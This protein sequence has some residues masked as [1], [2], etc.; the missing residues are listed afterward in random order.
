MGRTR[1]I[2]DSEADEEEDEDEDVDSSSGES[3]RAPSPTVTARTSPSPCPSTRI[4]TPTSPATTTSP[5]A[6]APAPRK[7]K[8]RPRDDWAFPS[9]DHDYGEHDNDEAAGAPKWKKAGPVRAGTTSM[10]SKSAS[11]RADGRITTE[12]TMDESESESESES[13]MKSADAN[14]DHQPARSSEPLPAPGG[15][16]RTRRSGNDQLLDGLPKPKRKRTHEQKHA[17]GEG[18]GEG[19]D[20]ATAH[21]RPVEELD[22]V[23]PAK[24]S[25]EIDLSARGSELSAAQK[26]AYELIESRSPAPTRP[27]AVEDLSREEETKHLST[28]ARGKARTKAKTK[29]T[30]T[31]KGR[32][33]NKAD[34][35]Q[36]GALD[37]HPP[38][39]SPEESTPPRDLPT[40][41]EEKA[42]ITHDTPP[43]P[44][45]MK[46]EDVPS[47]PNLL[48]A[49]SRSVL[50]GAGV[51]TGG[52]GQ[53]KG[54]KV[55]RVGLSRRVAI[56]SLLRV[57]K[58]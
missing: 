15:A 1:I 13:E 9:S 49:L 47:V 18:A 20:D 45:A 11:R 42:P 26:Q 33:K 48:P 38:A 34:E 25:I 46:R 27:P 57:L 43:K 32:A 44:S 2:H 17:R 35:T 40:F 6:T 53:E 12:V 56:P 29:G 10:T 24:P 3:E 16:R 7:S 8:K 55:H 50:G 5:A 30:G 41:E 51:K 37:H 31:G 39:A 54:I 4:P 58:K 14:T 21:C 22:V 36:M 19:E 28:R 52:V 23:Y